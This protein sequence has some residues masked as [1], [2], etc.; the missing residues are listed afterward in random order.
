MPDAEL[1]Q[2]L[3]R[4]RQVGHYEW[5]LDGPDFVS[6][7][8]VTKQLNAMGIMVKQNSVTSWF[9]DL[10]SAVDAGIDRYASREDVIKMLAQRF[11]R[12]AG[13]QAV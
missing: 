10:P 7:A 11:V 3:G 2:A 8:D 4:L 6:S 12:K 1:E 9:G 13:D 5:L